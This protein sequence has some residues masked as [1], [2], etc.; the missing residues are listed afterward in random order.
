M[1]SGIKPSSRL[2]NR[3][4]DASGNS[5]NSGG[6]VPVKAFMDTSNRRNAVMLD[7]SAAGNSPVPEFRREFTRGKR[8]ESESNPLQTRYVTQNGR[9]STGQQI[10]EVGDGG[11]NGAAEEILRQLEEGEAPAFRNGNGKRRV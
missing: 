10:K 6:I 7:H 5:H 1:L 9:N 4:S 11:R 3:F 8:V 2:L